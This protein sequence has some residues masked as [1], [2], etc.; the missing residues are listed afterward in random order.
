MET[1]V[2]ERNFWHSIWV[3]RVPNKIK[4]IKKIVWQPCREAIPTKANLSQRHITENAL[5]ER[6]LMEEETTLHALWSCSKLSS[7]W[8]A[9]EWSACQNIRPTNFKELLSWILNN[10]GSPELFAMLT[11]FCPSDLIAAQAKERLNEFNATIPPQPPVMPQPRTKWK[12]P[13][14]SAFKINFDGAI[15]RQEN[16]SKIGVVIWDHSGAVIASLAQLSTPAL[17]PI[18][19]EAIATARA[20]EFGQEIGITEAILEGDSELIINSLKA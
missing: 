10:H 6:C 15:F 16:K 1:Q 19:I 11:L 13:N 5:C 12:P 18:E 9:S 14:V 3:L 8:T 17:Q 7:A 2:E 20:L 4:I